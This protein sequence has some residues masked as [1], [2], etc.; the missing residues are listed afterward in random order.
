MK[1]FNL[2]IGIDIGIILVG[3]LILLTTLGMPKSP[4]GIGPG[5]YPRIISI[6][7]IICGFLLLLQETLH[8]SPIKKLY[9]WESLKRVLLLIGV[10]LAYVYLVDYIGFLYLTPLLML[11]TMYL[12]EFKKTST[13]ILISITVTVIVYYIFHNIFKVSLP[14]FS[15]F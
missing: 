4:L 13:A 10:S 14:S 15:L 5:D 6:G 8:P 7:L 9:S 11:I 12:F 2:N 3:F 1:R